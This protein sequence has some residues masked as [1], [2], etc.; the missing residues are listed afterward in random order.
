VNILAL[1]PRPAEEP[2]VDGDLETWARLFI[3]SP[4]ITDLERRDRFVVAQLLADV[5]ASR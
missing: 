5:E 3:L 2:P 1:A 4:A